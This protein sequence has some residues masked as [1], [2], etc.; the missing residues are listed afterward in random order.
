[1]SALVDSKGIE[2]CSTSHLWPQE[3]ILL[4]Q[5]LSA[6]PEKQE[7]IYKNSSPLDIDTLSYYFQLHICLMLKHMLASC[8]DSLHCFS[9]P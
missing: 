5:L 6:N 3:N 7:K 4:K 1:M 9:V 2:N 8:P